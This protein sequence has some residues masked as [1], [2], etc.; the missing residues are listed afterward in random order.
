LQFL[1][2][3]GG[4]FFARR[5]AG[6]FDIAIVI[7]PREERVL[8][9]LHKESQRSRRMRHPSVMLLRPGFDPHAVLDRLI[10][11]IDESKAPG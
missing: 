7:E 11:K 9:K 4:V 2:G 10:A 8:R 6:M 1:D 5:R 3:Q